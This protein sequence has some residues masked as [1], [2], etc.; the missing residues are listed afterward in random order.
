M[1][2]FLL[3]FILSFFLYSCSNV[4]G[5]GNII[6]QK[7][8]V[9]EF[10]GISAS[11]GVEVELRMGDHFEVEAE[12]DDNVMEFLVTKV[13]D[14]TLK[15]RTREVNL[16]NAHLKVYVTAPAIDY[17]KA[18]ASA[19]IDVMDVLKVAGKIKLLSSS[20]ATINANIDAPEV[21]IEASSSSKITVSGRS[22]LVKAT[23]SSSG[24]IEAGNLLSEQTKADASSSASVVVFASVKLDA[25]ASSSGT[26]RYK[27]TAEVNSSTNSSGVV[28]KE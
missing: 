11:T 16:M 12:A 10:T 6:T 25:H 27:G 8:T 2:K 9:K 3:F 26:V 21:N 4:T 24:E 14:Q 22:K 7:R 1:Q 17:I 5:S 20:S 18:S 13:E 23:A 19:A 15:I 28:E